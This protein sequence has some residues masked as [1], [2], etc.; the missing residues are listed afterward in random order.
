MADRTGSTWNPNAWHWE[1]KNYS[2]VAAAQLKEAFE[3]HEFD[4]AGE[5]LKVGEVEMDGDVFS[6]IRKGKK[7]FGYDFALTLKWTM[8]DTKGHLLLPEV[9]YGDNDVEHDFKIEDCDDEQRKT[10]I[11]KALKGPIQ[12]DVVA[13]VLRILQALREGQ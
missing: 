6:T 8:G 11:K 3:G 7:K 9:T 5:K 13:R 12:E 1:E 4:V 2:K 10:A